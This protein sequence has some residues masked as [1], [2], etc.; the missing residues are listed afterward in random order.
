MGK[1]YPHVKTVPDEKTADYVIQAVKEHYGDNPSWVIGESKK[2][3]LSNGE[4]EVTVELTK[5]E[6]EEVKERSMKM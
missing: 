2:E 3:K 4:I 5:L 1:K 6:P